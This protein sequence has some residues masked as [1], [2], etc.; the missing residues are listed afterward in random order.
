M[1]GL[2]NYVV[3]QD[4][5]Y[6]ARTETLNRNLA[7]FNNATRGGIVL[8]RRDH[9]GDFSQS[10]FYKSLNTVRRRDAY[11]SAP[12]SSVE[13]E[14]GKQ[15]G[16]KIAAG[17][18]TLIF[19]ESN[20]KWIQR[21]PKEAGTMFGIQLAKQMFDDMLQVGI[22]S[23][24]AATS[25]VTAVYQDVGANP[26][27]MSN[28]VANNALFG[29]ASSRIVCRVMHSATRY[30]LLQQGLTNSASL[31]S[32]DN[33]NVFADPEGKPFVVTDMPPLV[34]TGSPPDYYSLGLTAGA[35]DL[36]DNDTFRDNFD[37]KN[38]LENIQDT[39][40]A[41]WSYTL[42]LK[43]YSWDE[44]T[45]GASPNNAALFSSANWDRVATDHK[46]LAGVL[47]R[48]L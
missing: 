48:S 19:Y 38:G 5:V 40:Q 22:G 23:F 35:I 45:G 29:D 42:N 30:S 1:P 9:T 16:V 41:E 17:T 34:V 13:M 33:V 20:L 39:Y 31:F 28:I 6:R 8:R 14:M 24:I 32:W 25:N 7:L 2:S 18:P 12:I 37:P 21:D 4:W 15:T 46:D 47:L 43:G 11:S 36:Q 3:F 44:T 27:T 26:H 10:T